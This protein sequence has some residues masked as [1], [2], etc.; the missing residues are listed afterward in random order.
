MEKEYK[1][2]SK[3]AKKGIDKYVKLSSKCMDKYREAYKEET[4]KNAHHINFKEDYYTF[5]AKKRLKC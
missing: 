1:D 5:V 2:F 4:G 3:L